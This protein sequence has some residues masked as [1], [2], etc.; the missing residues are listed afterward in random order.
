MT[1]SSTQFVL[2]NSRSDQPVQ[3]VTWPEGLQSLTFES[4]VDLTRVDFPNSL[5]YLNVE[6]HKIPV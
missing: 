6:G 3:E 5:T 2:K 4:R 1:D